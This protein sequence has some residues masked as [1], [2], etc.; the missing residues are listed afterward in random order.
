MISSWPPCGSDINLPIANKVTFPVVLYFNETVKGLNSHTVSVETE[1]D[2]SKDITWSPLST[3]KFGCGQAWV[4]H[5]SIPHQELNSSKTYEVKIRS[6]DSQGITSLSGVPCSQPWSFSFRVSV[7]LDEKQSFGKITFTDESFCTIDTSLKS[8]QLL[9]SYFEV[10]KSDDE[11]P[12][13]SKWKLEM[14]ASEIAQ[15][16]E[17]LTWAEWYVCPFPY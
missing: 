7:C 14:I 15:Y 10:T 11:H 8:I 12:T 2:V 5:L 17:L 13:S 16:R 6:E 4:T 3:N 9:K 1:S